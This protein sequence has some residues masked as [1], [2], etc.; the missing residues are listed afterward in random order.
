M[1]NESAS[2]ISPVLC[3]F[4]SFGRENDGVRHF[5]SFPFFTGIPLIREMESQRKSNTKVKKQLVEMLV[6]WYVFVSNSY[7]LS[8]HLFLPSASSSLF[9][10]SHPLHASCPSPSPFSFSL[11]GSSFICLTE[12][13]ISL[14][15][16]LLTAALLKICKIISQYDIILTYKSCLIK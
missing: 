7:A 14:T 2:I 12:L 11:W 3:C 5:F 4:F 8:H 10:S 6:L 13:Y 16:Q 9:F 1:K 15:V